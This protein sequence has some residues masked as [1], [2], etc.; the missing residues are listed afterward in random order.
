MN[1][2]SPSL[3]CDAASSTEMLM[4]TKLSPGPCSPPPNTTTPYLYICLS[5]H[6]SLRFLST[7]VVFYPETTCAEAVRHIGGS[8]SCLRQHRGAPTLNTTESNRKQCNQK[9]WPSGRGLQ[10]W[11]GWNTGTQRL[12]WRGQRGILYMLS[13]KWCFVRRVLTKTSVPFWCKRG[14]DQ[15]S[16]TC[17]TTRRKHGNILFMEWIL[18]LMFQYLE[19]KKHN[20]H[21]TSFF[22]S[23]A[24]SFCFAF[25]H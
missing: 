9:M 18:Q 23:S 16:R 25:E 1:M 21:F 20:C 19:K 3:K 8:H 6:L 10:H 24:A 22:I 14:S 11:N 2:Q 15:N 5:L 17:G 4:S 13:Y 7:T 12:I